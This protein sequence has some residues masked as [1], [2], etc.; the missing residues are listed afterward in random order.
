MISLATIAD[1][2]RLYEL[3]SLLFTQEAEFE[4]TPEAPKAGL[5]AIL[6]NFSIGRILKLE[7]GRT[8][9]RYGKRALYDRHGCSR[10]SRNT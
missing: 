4:L 3:L 10:S 5:E 8:D 1:V 2:P 7:S 9:C 6:E